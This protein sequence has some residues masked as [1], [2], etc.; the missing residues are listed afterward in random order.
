MYLLEGWQK[1]LQMWMDCRF[2]YR[3]LVFSVNSGFIFLFSE[4]STCCLLDKC[5]P[6]L[7]VV[8]DIIFIYIYLYDIF[9]H[10]NR[11]LTVTSSNM[12]LRLPSNL[13]VLNELNVFCFV[14]FLIYHCIVSRLIILFSLSSIPLQSFILN[15]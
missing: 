8:E 15:S 1:H 6:Y 2:V 12:L 3:F 13:Q 4:G 9:Y 10:S 11:T 14:L 5:D 7:F